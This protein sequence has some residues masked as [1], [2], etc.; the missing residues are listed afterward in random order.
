[1][2]T[3]SHQI[4]QIESAIQVLMRSYQVWRGGV[5][6]V[7]DY[8]LNSCLSLNS[9]RTITLTFGLIPLKKFWTILFH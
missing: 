1:M 2:L 3:K 5:C 7:I 4:G 8:V 6:D 9:S